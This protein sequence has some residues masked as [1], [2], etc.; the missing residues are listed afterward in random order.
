MALE[1]VTITHVTASNTKK[2]G[3][4]I[5]SKFG[6]PS[7]IV[8]LKTNEYGEVWLNGFLPFDTAKWQGSTQ[9]IEVYEE[10]WQG[11]TQKKFKLPP[12]NPVLSD[13]DKQDIQK[14]KEDA[15]N[16]LYSVNALKQQLVAAGIL[17]D[18]IPGTSVEYPK[19]EIRAED[20]TFEGMSAEDESLMRSAEGAMS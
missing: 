10:E 3:T 4:P 14:A 17:K 9:E 18:V 7:W 6:K 13:T 19:E 20:V 12:R 11:R 15:Y 5:L 1:K 16:A 2:D 8:G